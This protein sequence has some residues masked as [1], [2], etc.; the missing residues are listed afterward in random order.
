MDICSSVGLDCFTELY[1]GSYSMGN[2]CVQGQGANL[3]ARVT[4]EQ[5]LNDTLAAPF[6]NLS[7]IEEDQWLESYSANLVQSLHSL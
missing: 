1:A 4:Y 3:S 6:L 5:K 2:T 7:F